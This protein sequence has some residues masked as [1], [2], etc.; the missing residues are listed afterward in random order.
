MQQVVVPRAPRIWT[1]PR[2][3]VLGCS[4]PP[5]IGYSFGVGGRAGKS[6]FDPATLQLTGWWRASYSASPWV[7]MASAGSSGANNL[8]E[9]TNPPASISALGFTVADFDG[10]NDELT[11]ADTLDTYAAA[12]AFSGWQLINVDAISTDN[13]A[14]YNNDSTFGT[15]T[16][17]YFGIFLKSGGGSPTVHAYLW[18]GGDKSVSAS[19]ATGAWT[20]VQWKVDGTNITIRVNGDAWQSSA[21]GNIQSLAGGVR[22]GGDRT[23]TEM[24]DGKIAE[25]G[26]IDAVLSDSDF[27]NIK[28]YINTRYALAL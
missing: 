13:A 11:A 12:G 9:A 15:K 17:T 28:S 20:L 1:P 7:G 24:Y 23:P 16:S 21:A 27:A 4:P 25:T 3:E 5:G 18:D 19:I 6:T 26:L 14:V 2:R 8:S 22:L 10:T